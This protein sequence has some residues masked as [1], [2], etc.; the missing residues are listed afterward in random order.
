MAAIL[1]ECTDLEALNLLRNVRKKLHKDLD[2]FDV[3]LAVIKAERKLNKDGEA[4]EGPVLAL[5]GYECAATIKITPLNQRVLKVPDA[6]LTINWEQWDAL[7]KGEKEALLDHELTHLV[8][9]RDAENTPRYDDLGRPL[10]RM[11]KHDWHLGGFLEVVE[12]HGIQSLDASSVHAVATSATFK[13]QRIFQWDDFVDAETD[14]EHEQVQ[15]AVARI[16]ASQGRTSKRKPKGGSK[17]FSVYSGDEGRELK[18]DSIEDLTTHIVM[19]AAEKLGAQADEHRGK[20][21]AGSRK[22]RAKSDS[23]NTQG[24]N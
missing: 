22:T 15:S 9:S 8:I 23:T 19:D 14:N 3:T 4:T 5:H 13:V 2:E 10:L 24:G 21:G 16:E 6:I 17:Q 1:T 7:T 12:R 20:K 11:R 18:F